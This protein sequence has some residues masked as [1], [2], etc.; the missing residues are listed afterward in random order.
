MAVT[1]GVKVKADTTAMDKLFKSVREAASLTTEVGYFEAVPVPDTNLTV[2]VLAA[3][4]EYG[5]ANIPA[6]PFLR[7][8]ATNGMGLLERVAAEEMAKVADGKQSP[9]RAMDAIGDAAA[10]R[11]LDTLETAQSWAAPNAPETVKR[12]G[13][14]T[15]LLGTRGQLREE[16]KY[17]VN[18]KGR[19][20]LRERPRS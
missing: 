7:R 14:D 9:V 15:P 1:P 4:Q 13:H 12:K 16:L 10:G 5:T 18:D 20:L 3:I 6:R 19:E 17:S 11:V 8:A 2:P